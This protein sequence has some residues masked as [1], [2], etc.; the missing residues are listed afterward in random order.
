MRLFSV[1]FLA[2]L[3]SCS[4]YSGSSLS[5]PVATHGRCEPISIPMCKDIAYNQ[6]IFPNLMGQQ[7]QDAAG[8]HMSQ[9]VPLIKINCSP[10]IHFFL[11][12]MYAPVCTILD[13][14]IPPCRALCLAARR[15]CEDVML[16]FDYPWP[17]EFECSKFPVGGTPDELCVGDADQTELTFSTANSGGRVVPAMVPATDTGSSS[18]GAGAGLGGGAGGSSSG[19][20]S[21]GAPTYSQSMDFKC[22]VQLQMPPGNKG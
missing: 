22:P 15:N 16:Q 18:A 20:S 21:G 19:A 6:T 1:L 5:A 4:R 13:S 17:A 2:S 12:A 9:Y 10:H 7:T 8:Q 14:A 11:C 3:A